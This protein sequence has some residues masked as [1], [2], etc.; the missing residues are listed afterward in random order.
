MIGEEGGIQEQP[1]EEG[2]KRYEGEKREEGEER[3]YSYDWLHPF[4][5]PKEGPR[6][7]ALTPDTM[8]T[9]EAQTF[10]E[11]TK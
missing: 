11:W 10:P 9:C 5:H 2:E 7:G 3:V 8:D 6:G 1:L 4:N